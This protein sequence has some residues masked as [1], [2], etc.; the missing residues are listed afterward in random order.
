[1][2]RE[3]AVIGGGPGGYGAAIGLAQAGWAV[4]LI[5]AGAVGGT[6]LHRGCIPTKTMLETARLVRGL[7]RAA[8]FGVQ[9]PPGEVRVDF[10]ALRQRQSQVVA[11]LVEGLRQLLAAN[12]VE[13][14]A[15]RGRLAAGGSGVPR[16]VVDG[17]QRLELA[18]D[19]VVLAP[20]SRPAPP[21]IPGLD[22]PGVVDSDG[23]L[24][25][26]VQP[27]RLVVIGA[28]VV[29]CELACA[30]AALG[31]EVTL[32]EALPQVLPGAD[33]D[34]ARRLEAGLRRQG[35]ALQTGV[36]VQ[37]IGADLVVR[38]EGRQG[39]FAVATDRVLV[40]TGRRAA[41]DGLGLEEVGG[42]LRGGTI[43]V[44]QELR[45]VG[46]SG[47]WAL[48]DAIGA[49]G[50]AH[51]AFLQAERLV[52]SI[53][54]RPLPPP[55]PVPHPVYTLPEVAWVGLDETAARAAGMTPTVARTPHA[56]L[57]RA[58]IAGEVD[59]FSK[60][61]AVDGRVVGVHLIGPHATELI[62]TAT[63]AVAQR[64]PVA[65]LAAISLPHPTLSEGLGEA[66]ALLLGLPRH[67][68]PARGG[69]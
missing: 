26:S 56:A 30:Y 62:G 66:A 58:V 27:A 68:A 33:A 35:I 46:L 25:D 50:L 15:G 23:L 8:E 14:L 44:D 22:R 51:A 49:P 41:T 11:R 21:P 17:A 19:A 6:C 13:V 40:A 61:V 20:G 31:T 59:G 28:G 12:G 36:R 43:V 18:P 10:G 1:M 67:L 45:C 48:G 24:A 54:G 57:G 34:V 3:A 69:R 39:A 53:A 65:E 2:V 38:G 55:S 29:G 16:V 64:L 9:L 52:A 42:Q 5:E 63:L 47:V 32:L 7:A 4:R 37:E 60:V